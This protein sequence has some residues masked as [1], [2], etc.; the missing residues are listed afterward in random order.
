M[1]LTHLLGRYPLCAEHRAERIISI[2][3]HAVYAG[4][5][6]KVPHSP[7][8]GNRVSIQRQAGVEHGLNIA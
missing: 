1:M 2:A 6:Q 5:I 7:F 4:N 8:S 3:C